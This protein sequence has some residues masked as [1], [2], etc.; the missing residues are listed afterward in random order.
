MK[1]LIAASGI[2]ACLAMFMPSASTVAIAD[3]HPPTSA[4]MQCD[5]RAE[6]LA[7]RCEAVARMKT[8]EH[9]RALFA[10]RRAGWQSAQTTSPSTNVAAET[11]SP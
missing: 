6:P 11:R 8:Q 2:L 5:P 4:A 3:T 1:N 7:Q 10:A 9:R